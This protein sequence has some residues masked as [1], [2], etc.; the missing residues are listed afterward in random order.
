MPGRLHARLCHAFLVFYSKQCTVF[1]L[2]EWDTQTD[3]QAD[4]QRDDGAVTAFDGGFAY[5]FN[6]MPTSDDGKTEW[7][8]V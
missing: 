2:E 4:K 5:R 3:M 1:E 8:N 7:T 6:T